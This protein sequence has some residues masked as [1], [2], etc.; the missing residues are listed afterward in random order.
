MDTLDSF[1]SIAAEP[2]IT[3][4]PVFNFNNSQ[5]L[6]S[7]RSSSSQSILP[8]VHLHAQKRTQPVHDSPLASKASCS[9]P[10][11]LIADDDAFQ[12]LYYQ[13]LLTR[14]V[15]IEAT[16]FTKRAFKFEVCF[17]GEELLEKLRQTRHCGCDRPAL[18]IVDYNMGGDKLN[19]V[20]T[21]I[22]IRESGYKGPIVLRTSETQEHLR[23]RHMNF[24][25]MLKDGRI[26]MLMDKKNIS[27]SK[28][29]IQKYLTQKK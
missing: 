4:V 9:C 5:K 25:Q 28:E 15:N 19:G 20:Q 21:A 2:K 7:T 22:K 14:S 24:E 12:H 16:L 29:A 10:H 27:E 17:S 8:Q 13:S 3:V 6:I 18:I 23:T 26:N 1:R 11:V